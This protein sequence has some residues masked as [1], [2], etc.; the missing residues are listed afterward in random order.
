[1]SAEATTNR[2]RRDSSTSVWWAIIAAAVALA[3]FLPYPSATRVPFLAVALGF[4]LWALIVAIQSRTHPNK[5]R[6]SNT[7]AVMAGAAAVAMVAATVIG[8][9]YDRNHPRVVMIEAF[10]SAPLTVESE[11]NA[12]E[13]SQ[14]WESGNRFSFIAP[15][16]EISVTVTA[17]KDSDL[18]TECKIYIDD[19]LVLHERSSTESATCTY[20]YPWR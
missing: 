4:A 2:E 8:V 6:M 16:D 13:F 5:R 15:G 3:A 10:G 19:E 9:A 17:P 18:D 1:M 7:L 20:D 14:T 12:G 11:T